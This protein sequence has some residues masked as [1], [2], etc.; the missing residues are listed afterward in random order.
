MFGEP[1]R[2]EVAGGQIE[3]ATV[4]FPAISTGIYSYPVEEAASIALR[5]TYEFLRD[6]EARKTIRMVRF[7][8]FKEN[9]LQ[10]FKAALTALAVQET[11]IRMI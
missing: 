3:L 8:L 10:G 6:P 2:A 4:A 7:V 11:D 9:V 1:V 5:T